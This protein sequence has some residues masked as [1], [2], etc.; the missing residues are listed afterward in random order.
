MNLKQTEIN[1]IGVE[2]LSARMLQIVTDVAN[3]VI[4]TYG[5]YGQNTLVQSVDTVYSTKDGWTVL[6]NLNYPYNGVN[7]ALKKLIQDCA[8]SVLLKAGDGTTTVT[9]LAQRMYQGIYDEYI[10]S[11][12][13]RAKYNV[14]EIEF[15]LREVVEAICNSMITSAVSITDDNLEKSIKQLALISTNWDEEM[16][17]FIVDI[18]KKTKNPIIKFENSGTERSY[19]E[20][21]EGYDLKGQLILSDYYLTNPEKGQCSVENPA[22]L[23]FN[24]DI[25][26]DLVAPLSMIADHFWNKEHKLLVIMAPGFHQNFINGLSSVNASKLRSGNDVVPCVPIKYFVNMNIDKDCAQDLSVLLGTIM[27]AKENKDMSEMFS[28]V[29]QSISMYSKAKMDTSVDKQTEEQYQMEMLT[30]INVAY[31]YLSSIAGTCGKLVAT[32]K[33]ILASELNNADTKTLNERKE[34]LA[35]EIDA[36]MK[37]AAALSMI[38]EG[39]RMKRIRLGKLQLNMGTIYVGGFGDAHLKSRRDALD[40]ATKACEAAYTG[41]GYTIGGCISPLLAIS[42]IRDKMNTPL[43]EKLCTII[44]NSYYGVIEAMYNNKYIG[45]KSNTELDVIIKSAV[46]SGKGYNL[47]TEEYDESLISPVACDVEI[48]KGVMSLIIVIVGTN[49]M[50]IQDFNSIDDVNRLLA[51][52]ESGDV[53]L[54]NNIRLLKN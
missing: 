15:A 27:V 22:V 3:A 4:P 16:S 41:D 32:D 1:R 11:E 36:K 44:E 42:N 14:K 52:E 35:Y 17:D 40:D 13:K 12:E 24:Y 9:L 47:I 54:E 28:D 30:T 46:E 33:Y 37:E 50:I 51:I 7:N 20:Y 48:L 43:K 5:P 38:T 49:Q 29:M 26:E 21:T 34:K 19:V 31:E 6:Q 39:I 2:S 45:K 8:Q 53:S 18:Y 23:M 25:G 10:S